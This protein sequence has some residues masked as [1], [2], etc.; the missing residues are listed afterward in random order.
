MNPR[1]LKEP[2]KALLVHLKNALIFINKCLCIVHWIINLGVQNNAFFSSEYL[3]IFA[4][5]LTHLLVVLVNTNLISNQ[6]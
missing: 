4:C 2:L 3:L 1:K 5:N 6:N